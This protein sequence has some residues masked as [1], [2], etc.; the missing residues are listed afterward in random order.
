VE[1]DR[2]VDAAV[3]GP[4]RLTVDAAIIGRL[5]FIDCTS[6]AA[7]IG[8]LRFTGSTA[9]FTPPSTVGFYAPPPVR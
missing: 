2:I 5:R 3:I 8:P 9:S 1:L 4:L 6:D 7:I